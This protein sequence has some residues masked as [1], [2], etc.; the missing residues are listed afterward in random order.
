MLITLGDGDDC[1]IVA[2]VKRDDWPLEDPAGQPLERVRAVRDAI[3]TRVE[4]LLA[5]LT[6]E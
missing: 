1:P 5:S 3:R 2:G 6:G 4:A